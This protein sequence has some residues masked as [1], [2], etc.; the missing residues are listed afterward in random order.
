VEAASFRKMRNLLGVVR[1]PQTDPTLR[2]IET[3]HC[4]SC[5]AV[6]AK[7]RRGGTT[8]TNPGC[9]ECGYLGWSSFS[10]ER[11][12]ERLRSFGDPQ[13]NRLVRSR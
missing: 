3:V 6:Y 12:P 7:P 2:L 5:S 11:R 10:E 8:E 1:T 13:R 4:L 9:P